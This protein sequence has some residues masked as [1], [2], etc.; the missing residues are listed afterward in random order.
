MTRE[1]LTADL[2]AMKRAG[3]G[4]ALF[5]E[6]GIGIPRGPVQFM[7]EEWRL[8]FRHAVREAERLG[9]EIALGTGPGWCGSGGPWVKP[10]NSMQHLVGAETA[11]RGP[12]RWEDVPVRPKPRTPYFGER[13]LTPELKKQWESFYED[14]LVLA[15]P[16]PHGTARTADIDEKALYYRAPYSSKVGVRPFLDAP[17]EHP[18]ATPGSAVDSARVIDLTAR[19]GSDGKLAWDVP[20]GDW[21]ILRLG[22]TLTGQTTRPA[23]APGLGFESDKFDAAAVDAHFEA[24]FGTLIRTIGEPKFKDRGLTTLHFDSWEMSSQNWSPRFR[25]EFARRRGYEPLRFLPALLGRV[26]DSPE[27][28]ERF[29]WDY[30]LTAQE[31]VIEK[32]AVRLR[33]LGRRHGLRFSLEPY[34]LNPCA[35]LALGGVADIPQGEFWSQG[36]GFLS[37]YSCIE[38]ASIAHTLGR[39]VVAAEAFT[40]NGNEA[41][42]QHPGSMKAQG[43]WAFCAGINRFIFHRYQHQPWLDRFPGMTMGPYGVYWERTQTWWDMVGAYHSYLAR[44]Q[45]VL[46]QGH[47]IADVLYLTP[48]GAPHVFRPPGTAAAKAGALPDHPGHNYDGC[49]PETL[50]ATASVHD[51]AIVF[52][53]GTAYRLLVLPDFPT[54]T[55]RLL[56]KVE[57]LLN[58]GATVVGE[59]PR[60]SPG[61][62]GHPACDDQVR[63][64]AERIWGNLQPGAE[65]RV[66]R[67][68]LVRHGPVEPLNTDARDSAKSA[69][70]VPPGSGFRDLYP[71]FEY[72]SGLLARSGLPADFVADKPLRFI[73][74]RVG[75]AEVYFVANGSDQPIAASC[76]FRVS[77]LLPEWWDP[78]DGTRRTLPSFAAAAEGCTEL[79]LSLPAHGS[80]FVVFRQSATGSPDTAGLAN[81]GHESASRRTASAPGT[82]STV[83]ATG[84]PT[85]L[86]TNFPSKTAVL[87]LTAPWEV[88]F[89]PRWGGPERVVFASLVDWTSRPEPGIRHYSGKATYRTSFDLPSPAAG[90]AAAQPAHE[91]RADY[92]LSLGTVKN[93]ASVRLNGRE[94]GVVWCPPWS[95]RIPAAVLREKGNRLEITVANLWINRLIGDL[96]LPH[97]QRYAFATRHPYK[98]DS[99][100]SPSGLLGPVR[101]LR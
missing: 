10:E 98:A 68:R 85:V 49:D 33:E 53:H 26:V 55:P 74:R 58:A 16:T 69:E 81:S 88:S 96:P 7:S 20:D 86:S 23:P 5:L 80:G 40:A 6:V 19:L 94:L 66:G 24:F 28:T 9:I 18:A 101:L 67:G 60:K 52:P 13:S 2:E 97:D 54:M 95:V 64:T 91:V 76:R 90:E 84:T 89:S 29:L 47:S 78:V 42:K 57:A 100:L 77:A 39:P 22:R 70:Q 82:I 62:S 17:A 46:Q 56:A 36:F 4:G 61:L 83:A 35:D 11:V 8:L 63:T 41:W 75:A 37:E 71:S 48:E 15:Y 38:A 27:I 72:I 59:P 43:D 93:L 31:L 34:D 65:R 25:E 14:V 3:I 32:H 1:G 21:T 79:A 44:C 30:R 73:H 51:G 45:A 12:V 99:P 92:F 50:I 87:E